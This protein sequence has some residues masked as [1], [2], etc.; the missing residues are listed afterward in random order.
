MIA[1][2]L[3]NNRVRFDINQNAAASGSLTLSSKLLSVARTVK[4]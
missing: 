4:K 2:V 3:E 1:F